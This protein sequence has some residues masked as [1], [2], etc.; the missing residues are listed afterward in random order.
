MTPGPDVVLRCP[1][2]AALARAPTIASGTTLGGEA[3]TD[4][5]TR[6]PMM[7]AAVSATRCRGCSRVFFV[8]DAEV[9]GELDAVDAVFER[10]SPEVP[11]EWWAASR[12]DS[13]AGAEW[14]AAISAGA[15]RTR[16]QQLELRLQA[17]WAGNDAFRDGAGWLAFA[18]RG[19]DE[20]ENAAMLLELLDPEVGD[21]GLLRAELLRELGRFGEALTQLAALRAEEAWQQVAWRIELLAREEVAAVR[22]IPLR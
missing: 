1:H 10:A 11:A 18:G 13:L 17:W 20:R 16:E 8:A 5:R 2:C 4:G 9:V 21:E 15:G 19:P 7:P 3:W 6:L 14:S 22:R 12:L